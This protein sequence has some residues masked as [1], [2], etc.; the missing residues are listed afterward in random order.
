MKRRRWRRRRQQQRGAETTT[1][2]SSLLLL[3]CSI[4]INGLPFTI[5]A[6]AP[7]PFLF[8]FPLHFAFKSDHHNHLVVSRTKGHRDVTCRLCR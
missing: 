6:G 3:T 5:L 2:S 8:L 4:C 1:A 7:P